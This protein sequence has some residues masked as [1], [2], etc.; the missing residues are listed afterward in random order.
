MPDCVWV[1]FRI[2]SDALI[3]VEYGGPIELEVFQRSREATR[4]HRFE[5]GLIEH[6][7]FAFT[8]PAPEPMHLAK[9]IEH[10]PLGA[11]LKISRQLVEGFYRR[12]SLVT[13]FSDFPS[14][15]P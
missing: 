5:L 12:N 2:S 1:G 6:R 4:H 14:G 7:H 8:A 11:Y 13:H 10:R 15:L 3:C 9:I